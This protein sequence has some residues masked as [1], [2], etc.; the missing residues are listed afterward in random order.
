MSNPAKLHASDVQSRTWVQELKTELISAKNSR[1]EAY[2]SLRMAM[3]EAVQLQLIEKEKN[4]SP[5]FAM[6]ISLQINK[7][8]WSMLADGKSFAEAEI[9]DMVRVILQTLL[10]LPSHWIYDYDRDYTDVGI[11][12]F[13][14]KYF[15]FRNCLPN[16]KSD[17]I[18]SAWN[19]PPDWGKKVM[20]RVDAKQGA[21]KDG[22]SPFELFQVEIYPL[23][24]HLTESMYRMM[25]GYLFSEEVRDSQRRQEVWKV[26]TTAGARRVRRGSTIPEAAASSSNPTKESEAPS[27]SGISAMLFPATSQPSAQADSQ[28]SKA[29]NAKA[30]P[31]TGPTS[32][33]KRTSSD[34]KGEETVTE[35]V[36]DEQNFPS[37]KRGPSGSIEQLDDA[38]KNKPKDAKVVK[39][40]RSTPEE[41]KVAVPQEEKR[42]R[43]QKIMEFHNIKI[44]QVELCV[45]YEGQRFV[46]ND[47]KLLM[48][49]FHRVEFTGTWR[50]LCSRVKKHIIW[51]VLKS[52]TGMQGKK[53]KD[54]GQL[55]LPGAGGPEI[56]LNVTD[57]EGQAGKSDKLPPAWPK[58]PND[59]AGDGFVTSVKGLFNTQRRK[60]K[61]F[62][63]KTMKGEEN[64]TQGDLS[65]NAEENSPFARQLTIVKA[66]KL[67]KR[68][69]KK[70][71]PKGQKDSPTQQTEA[72]PPSQQIEALPSSPKDEIPFD[73]D[74]S[75]GSSSPYEALHE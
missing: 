60:A 1:K 50:R 41:K 44:S 23:K 21:P 33:L 31:S 4:K 51:G 65:E 43:P 34:K 14:A 32:E 57:N 71:Q 16:A 18:L 12:L 63:H 66:K 67:M 37:H 27:R 19:P 62:V 47:L 13:T 17:T 39:A 11:S 42:S 36:A 6:R 20:L 52:V 35:S 61:A 45:S 74:S 22:S 15:V 59:G 5:S 29:Q 8:V 9:N 55:L 49:Q 3:K 46:V 58:R 54:K 28:A 10:H 48:D 70:M 40:G 69:T 25:W 38:P 56:D 2:A 68:Q 30:N 7:V 75:S 53:F 26:S 72:Q 73:S 64:E 24:I